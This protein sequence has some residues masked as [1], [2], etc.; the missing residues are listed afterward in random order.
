[1][2]IGLTQDQYVREFPAYVPLKMAQGGIATTALHLLASCEPHVALL[3]GAMAATATLIEAVTR[4]IIK[5]LFSENESL[6]TLTQSCV[7]R[8]T[9]LMF[10]DSWIPWA[11]KT[12]KISILSFQF[13]ISCVLMAIFN[14]KFYDKKI[15]RIEVI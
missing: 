2:L 1:M 15:A 12:Y 6:I 4:P 14:E 8:M 13:L 9:V 11:G 10:V 3:W 7:P 5:S